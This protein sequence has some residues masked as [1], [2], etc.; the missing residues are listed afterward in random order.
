MEEHIRSI[1]SD[2]KT[3]QEKKWKLQYWKKKKK[4]MNLKPNQQKV[5]K[6]K[7]SEQQ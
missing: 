2:V 5:C 3:P 6:V 4:T 7:H 1:K